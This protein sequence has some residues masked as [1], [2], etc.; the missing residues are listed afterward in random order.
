MSDAKDLSAEERTNELFGAEIE[1]KAEATGTPPKAA[2]EVSAQP[3]ETPGHGLHTAAPSALKTWVIANARDTDVS[4][5]M[6]LLTKCGMSDLND[7]NDMASDLFGSM[8]T[9]ESVKPIVVLRLWQLLVHTNFMDGQPVPSLRSVNAHFNG[10][11]GNGISPTPAASGSSTEL[12]LPMP[13]ELQMPPPPPSPTRL[14]AATSTPACARK[15]AREALSRPSRRSSG[16]FTTATL[17]G[18]LGGGFVSSTPG[19][20]GASGPIVSDPWEILPPLERDHLHSGLASDTELILQAKLREKMITS[21]VQTLT[22]F[23]DEPEDWIEWRDATLQTFKT[24]GRLIVLEPHYHAVA[25][26]AGWSVFAIEEADRWA[27]AVMLAAMAGCPTALDA[28]ELAPAGSGSLAFAELRRQFEIMGSYVKNKLRIQIEKFKPLVG[29]DPPT[30]IRRLDKLYKKYRLQMNPEPQSEESKVRKILALAEQF[31]ALEDK[32]KNIRTRTTTANVDPRTIEYAYICVDLKA[33]WL[34]WG[35]ESSVA[36][37]LSRVQLE[38]QLAA[39]QKRMD[40]LETAVAREKAVQI[41][42]AQAAASSDLGQGK[43]G[44]GAGLKEP[45][46]ERKQ[47]VDNRIDHGPCLIKDCQGRI[48]A[49]KN[50]KSAALC[51]ECWQSFHTSDETI[52]ELNDGRSVYKSGT[53]ARP[54]NVDIKALRLLALKRDI[55]PADLMLDQTTDFITPDYRVTVEPLRSFEGAMVALKVTR[56]VKNSGRMSVFVLMDS[57]GA[58]GACDDVAFFHG[59]YTTCSYGVA[60]ISTKEAPLT[61]GGSQ[62]GAVLFTDTKGDDFIVRYGGA[63]RAEP[64]DLDECLWSVSQMLQ[65]HLSSGGEQGA[66]TGEKSLTMHFPRG[67][68]V[69]TEFR[70]GLMG[71]H[72]T[73]LAKGDPRFKTLDVVWASRDEV[74]FPPDKLTP[75]DRK[76]LLLIDRP[77]LKVYAFEP[78]LVTLDHA[79]LTLLN[80]TVKKDVHKDNVDLAMRD[81]TYMGALDLSSDSQKKI[82]T[83]RCGGFTDLIQERMLSLNTSGNDV[84]TG[85]GRQAL[86]ARIGST[87]AHQGSSFPTHRRT[88]RTPKMGELVTFESGYGDE[89]ATDDY[90]TGI[91]KTPTFQ[92]ICDGK[93]FPVGWV[94]ENKYKSDLM[95]H[96]K[97][98]FSNFVLPFIVKGDFAKQLHFGKNEIM[99][100][101]RIVQLKSSPPYHQRLN[102]AERYMYRMTN[103]ATFIKLDSQLPERFTI[104]CAQHACLLLMVSPIQYRG[105]WT[106][107]YKLYFKSDF[108]YR[109]LKRIGC[110][111]YVKLQKSQRIKFG[112][113]GALGVLLGIGG[114]KFTDFTYKVWSPNEEIIFTRDCVFAEDYRPFQVGRQT[115]SVQRS[116]WLSLDVGVLSRSV[117]REHDV[118]SEHNL[119]GWD[120]GAMA[121]ATANLANEP[122]AF[123]QLSPDAASPIRRGDVC[124]VDQVEGKVHKVTP[125]GVTAVFPDGKSVTV[126]AS[127][128]FF[129]DP[130]NVMGR[131]VRNRRKRE[132]FTFTPKKVTRAQRDPLGLAL[133]GKTFMSYSTPDGCDKEFTILQTGDPRLFMDK[134]SKIPVPILEYVE[135]AK[136][137]DEDRDDLHQSTVQEVRKWLNSKETHLATATVVSDKDTEAAEAVLLPLLKMGPIALEHA[138]S[139]PLKKMSTIEKEKAKMGPSFADVVAQRRQKQDVQK[140][141]GVDVG[142]S[143]TLT[144][145][146]NLGPGCLEKIKATKE[147][148]QFRMLL[149]KLNKCRKVKRYKRVDILLMMKGKI[150]EKVRKR[151]TKFG[152][153]IPSDYKDCHKKSV[154]ESE[155]AKWRKE[156][157]EE[158]TTLVEELKIII[159]GFNIQDLRKEDPKLQPI[160]GLW[161]YDAHPPGVKLTDRR[162]R[163]VANGARD[164]EKGVHDSYSPVGQLV[165]A[166]VLMAV[167]QQT[168]MDLVLLDVGKAFW[169]GRLNRKAVYMW[170]A[171]G[172]ADFE[173]EVWKILGPIQGLDDSGKTFYQCMSEF[174]RLIGFKHAHND[175]TFFR[176]LRGPGIK[177]PYPTHTDD[178]EW[179]RSA[180]NEDTAAPHVETLSPDS[181]AALPAPNIYG[182]AAPEHQVPMGPLTEEERAVL[183]THSEAEASFL[184]MIDDVLNKSPGM[185]KRH[186]YELALWY[187][188]DVAIGTFDTD[189]ILGELTRRFVRVTHHVNGGMFLGFDII[190][191]KAK[192]ILKMMLKT[193]ME[194]VVETMLA[195]DPEDVTLRSNVGILNWATS[196]IF[197]THVQEARLLASRCNMDE[198][199]DLETSVALIYEIYEKRAQGI[200]FRT[201]EDGAHLFEP[202]TSRV[203]GISDVSSPHRHKP[204]GDG[205]VIVTKEDI[206]ACDDG[207][208]VYED[209]PLLGKDF[210]EE[211]IPTTSFFRVETSVDATY[212]PRGE[213]GRSDI[214]YI[215]FVNG[216]PADWNPIRL[217]GVAD[218]TASA[219]YCG[220]SVGCKKGEAVRTLLRF[221][222]VALDEIGQT[223][224]STGAKQIAENPKKLGSTRNL[225]IRW[226]LVRYHIHALGLKLKYG[227]SEDL[228]ADMGTKRL[229]RKKLARFA[230]IFFNCLHVDWRSNWD[231]LKHICEV[232]VFPEWD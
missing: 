194:R 145:L 137:K 178:P 177:H 70:N 9:S 183:K 13:H 202:R 192:R 193:Y 146:T 46:R 134:G 184:E 179:R 163:W 79:D 115:L 100:R 206:L 147:R 67:H 98:N 158:I 164:P 29:E 196:T 128:P 198:L 220:Q 38:Q 232:G 62:P 50:L 135:T 28:F 182:T 136:I 144:P 53:D 14:T 213:D 168:N 36:I 175:P 49:P 68:V 126:P 24:A 81:F 197:G 47:R 157:I 18:T 187:V 203:D 75:L 32:V 123:L 51:G 26:S 107:G 216:A 8:P 2:P 142:A 176:R 92:V 76:A 82:L 121:V 94:Y 195:K 90:P 219:E 230:M 104:H 130:G 124:V 11:S 172:F 95:Q 69:E 199:E 159:K 3:S 84:L 71:L 21:A 181:T 66:F 43:P 155:Q 4:R 117:L 207:Y 103:V 226:H 201:L 54:R 12:K 80:K 33:Q 31:E 133:V 222:G 110:L 171:E 166:R 118:N 22:P 52:L 16:L 132:F 140:L 173:G 86:K 5:I 122:G 212:A 143:S 167:I 42:V 56:T 112:Q 39:T 186:Y 83:A 65:A 152:M 120:D 160:P 97:A 64:G 165:T 73:Y 114:F 190:Y 150:R 129:T 19:M 151:V 215:V 125:A 231:N 223:V 7:V 91:S 191:D 20:G 34:A 156:E 169:K 58:I 57:C 27:H 185:E 106:S 229:A 85:K 78:A 111:V 127:S 63:L 89:L 208:N 105:K 200:H 102:P 41:K 113:H 109:I 72:G 61:M 119:D 228:V 93:G 87:F 174:M 40:N 210:T 35:E 180:P 37:K 189:T 149:S 60:G 44:G 153:D 55:C 88:T 214:M 141:R 218:S 15:G 154:P 161:V 25:K 211:K 148:L 131:P 77:T 225:G 74:Y 99:C 17:N 23:T 170:A 139:L 1:A 162:A 209:D 10:T 101:D 48:F 227:I 59:N 96:L 45:E 138:R 108:D 224:D 30:M 217:T 188:D 116:H 205:G 204:T 221:A 6:K